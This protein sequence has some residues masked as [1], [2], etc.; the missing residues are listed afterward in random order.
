MLQEKVEFY[1]HFLLQAFTIAAPIYYAKSN[2]F[3]PPKYFELISFTGDVFF[4]GKSSQPNLHYEISLNKIL[5]MMNRGLRL[6]KTKKL[7]CFLV[8]ITEANIIA[9][10]FSTVFFWKFEFCTK[11]SMTRKY[12]RICFNVQKRVSTKNEISPSYLITANLS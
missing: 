7:P 11:T 8:R 9:L 5:T 4:S 3:R 12:K 6:R 10:N 2:I 1:K